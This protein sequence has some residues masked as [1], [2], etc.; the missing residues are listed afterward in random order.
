MGSRENI[1]KR[2]PNMRRLVSNMVAVSPGNISVTD[3][4]HGLAKCQAHSFLLTLKTYNENFWNKKVKNVYIKI[5][6]S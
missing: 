4:Y 1:L 2:N 5:L 6:I 3:C